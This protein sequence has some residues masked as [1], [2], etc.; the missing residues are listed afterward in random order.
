MKTGVK[1]C[2]LTNST[3]W[4]LTFRGPCIVIYSYNKNQRDALFLKFMLVK[5]ST[6]FGQVHCPSSGVSQHHIHAAGVWWLSA[7]TQPTEHARIKPSV[8]ACS[9]KTKFYFL[10]SWSLGVIPGGLGNLYLHLPKSVAVSQGNR[11]RGFPAQK[12]YPVAKYLH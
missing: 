2:G 3:V 6:C 1:C 4:N 5:Y 12:S 7:S 10:N 9:I 11:H 8:D